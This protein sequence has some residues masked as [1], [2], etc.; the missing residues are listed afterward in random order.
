MRYFFNVR[1]RRGLIRDEEG[2]ELRDMLAARHE[3]FLSARDF[4]L[5]DIKQGGPV[6]LRQI[7]ITDGDGI[8]LG[9]MPVIDIV[10]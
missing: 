4:A 3:A 8:V 7:E 10:H 9:T 6:R 2:S 1:D 5:E